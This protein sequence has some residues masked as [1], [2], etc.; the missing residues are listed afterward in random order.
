MKHKQ[1]TLDVKVRMLVAKILKDKFKDNI[2]GVQYSDV[3]SNVL[4]TRQYFT[5]QYLST[6]RYNTNG[7]K[8][9]QFILQGMKVDTEDKYRYLVSSF[10]NEF[11]D[12]KLFIDIKH[13]IALLVSCLQVQSIEDYEPL[14]INSDDYMYEWVLDLIASLLIIRNGDSNYENLVI[15]VLE[16][17]TFDEIKSVVGQFVNEFVQTNSQT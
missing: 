11:D 15:G 7:A 2:R 14:P 3:M 4:T 6:L 17:N 9:I 13:F 8:A 5:Q 10:L 1:G 12:T 16:S